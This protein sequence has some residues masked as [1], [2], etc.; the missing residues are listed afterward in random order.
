MIY[1]KPTF[2]VAVNQEM[3]LILKVQTHKRPYEEDLFAPAY[4]WPSYVFLDHK[5]Q[6]RCFQKGVGQENCQVRKSDCGLKIL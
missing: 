3:T 1:Q 2:Q 6:T 5:L 4:I